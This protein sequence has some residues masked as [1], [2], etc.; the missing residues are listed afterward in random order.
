MKKLTELY[1]QFKGDL[2]INDIKINSK[3]VNSGDLFVCISG[4]SAN[5]N[6]FVNE[7]IN[8]GSVA[9]LSN[10]EMDITVPLILVDDPDKELSILCQKFYDFN[11]FDFSIIGVT[12]TNGKTTV[13]SI[14]K[15]MIGDSCG[16][17]GTNGLRSSNI[18]ESIKNTTPDSA[19]LYKYFKELKDDN[20]NVISMEASSEAFYRNRLDNLLFDIGVVTN[21]TEDHL[22]IHKTLDNYLECKKKLV[23]SVKDNGYSI[24]NA[25]D[26]YFN[27]FKNVAKGTILTYGKNNTDLEIIDYEENIDNTLIKLKYKDNYFQVISPLVGEYNIYNLCAAILSLIALK[28]DINDIIEKVSDIT[29]PKGR[30]ESLEFGQDYKIILD[31]AHT[32]DAFLK[33]YSFLNK[34]KK[35]RVITVTGSAG[36]RE[37]EKRSVMGKVV[38]DN[39]DYVI[40]TMDDPRYEDVNKIIND[41]VSASDRN[42]YER[43][44]DRKEAIK[45]AFELAKKDDIVLITGKGRDNY[46]AIEDKYLPYNDYEII[47]DMFV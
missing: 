29:I 44:I 34:V 3:E 1:P 31:Y 8:N 7:A 12:G 42:N 9:V 6:N 5:R 39:S 15:D 36:G 19:K 4:V 33:I 45:K 17:I 11:P 30:C 25:D 41:L 35:G 16:Y 20:C 28:Y 46:M 38:I 2:L 21:V 37:K 40:F 10:K 26:K 22:N 32:T 13:A 47:K 24:L 43:I 27:E 14:I 18:D 23:E